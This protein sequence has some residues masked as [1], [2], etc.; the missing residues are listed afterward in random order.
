[1]RKEI[2]NSDSRLIS[3]TLKNTEKA[4]IDDELLRIEYAEKEHGLDAK[5]KN[6]TSEAYEQSRRREI[7]SS[8]NEKNNKS[9]MQDTEYNN[10][11][12]SVM[13]EN[14][15]NNK[16]LREEI[17]QTSQ[18]PIL[19]KIWAYRNPVLEKNKQIRILFKILPNH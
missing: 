5:S 18:Q 14:I 2:L 12:I 17:L 4:T 1:M 10:Y 6:V 13:P 8:I 9:I 19:L 16:Q 3:E 11:I 15:R 7:N